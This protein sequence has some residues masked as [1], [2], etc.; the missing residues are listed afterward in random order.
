MLSQNIVW[1]EELITK[2][3]GEDNKHGTPITVDMMNEW[4]NGTFPGQKHEYEYECTSEEAECLQ[5][6]R[7]KE[8]RPLLLCWKDMAPAYVIVQCGPDVYDYED[9][10]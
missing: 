10:S 6:A 5:Q 7:R 1:T 8:P 2:F 4:E 9:A 3:F